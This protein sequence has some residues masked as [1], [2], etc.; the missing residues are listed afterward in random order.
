MTRRFTVGQIVVCLGEN[1]YGGLQGAVGEIKLLLPELLS[2]LADY[3]VHF[4]AHTGQ[5]CPCGK[6]NV[7]KFYIRDQDLKPLDDPDAEVVEEVVKLT[8]FG[9]TT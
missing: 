6:H 2:G 1:H 8:D 5:R 7:D 9:F 3:A 4:P